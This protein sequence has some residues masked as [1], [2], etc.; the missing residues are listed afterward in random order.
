[1]SGWSTPVLKTFLEAG[2]GPVVTV[3]FGAADLGGL[4]WFI[5]AFRLSGYRTVICDQFLRAWDG[6]A[7]SEPFTIPTPAQSGSGSKGR[8]RV[9]HIV[10]G[11]RLCDLSAHPLS[12]PLML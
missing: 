5:V 8:Q 12:S 3:G 1:M 4:T 6:Y 10:L 2:R 7:A 9:L 11:A